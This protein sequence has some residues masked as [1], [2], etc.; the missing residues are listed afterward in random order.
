VKDTIVVELLVF[1]HRGIGPFVLGT[2]RSSI[3][4]AVGNPDYVETT[5][6][7]SVPQE[8]WHYDRLNVRLTFSGEH[9]WRLGSISALGSHAV[10]NGVRFIG[11]HTTDL[12]GL[13]DSA[14]IGDLL[15]DGDYG[16]YGSCYWSE[17]LGFM[18]WIESGY[19]VK[20]HLFPKFDA[21]GNQPCWPAMDEFP[22]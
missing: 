18:L 4:L 16:E 21:T 6:D 14:G 12:G 17:S 1:P 10:F 19:V 3:V 9:N 22:A 13:C 15:P 11:R 5:T 2:S 8:E 7:S 20:L